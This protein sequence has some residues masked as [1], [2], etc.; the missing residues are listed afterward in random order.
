M[1]CKAVLKDHSSDGRFNIKIRITFNRQVLYLKTEYY[2]FKED[3]DVKLGKLKSVKLKGK[4]DDAG[5][6]KKTKHDQINAKITNIIGGYESKFASIGNNINNYDI[7]S[8]IK[9][10]NSKT[11]NE[12][13]FFE[14]TNSFVNKL[15][16]HGSKNYP[17]SLF[18][19]INVLK[20]FTGKDSLLF[21]EINYRFLNDFENHLIDKGL[22]VNSIGVYM[23]NIRLIF[24]K[25]IN[26]D[27]IELNTYPF[28]KYKIR[29]EKTAKRNISINQITKIK[30]LE[31]TNE[32]EII[33]RD[34]FLLSFYLIGI[35]IIDM[36][37][38]EK[39]NSDR[40]DFR[41]SKTKRLYSIKIHSEAKKIIERYK[42]NKNAL[43]FNELYSD[44]R[45]F[46]KMLN[47]KLKVIAKKAEIDIPL[48]TY[49]ARHSWAT[50]ASE[51]DITKDVIR[52]ALGH[53]IDTVTDIYID[54]DMDKVDEANFK[55]INTI[56]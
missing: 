14:Y 38:L 9:I 53:G 48:S 16:K 17:D 39:T 41:R 25:A 19:T 26:D 34:I 12:A 18:Y 45:N 8:L 24:N 52:H 32:L 46:T 2:A 44:Y 36:L 54:F 55:V 29:K 40:I 28:R 51:L 15:R 49:Y 31:L 50:I 11:G 47:K 20:E 5:L 6:H 56:K 13:D 21:V 27:I 43:I 30:N 42:G 33:A 3:F 4:N 37:N 35:N 1:K 7:H 22:K 10:I 23:R